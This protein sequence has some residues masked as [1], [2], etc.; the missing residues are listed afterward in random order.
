MSGKANTSAIPTALSQLTDDSTHRVVTDTEKTAWN[1]KQDALTFDNVPTQNSNNPVKSGGIKTYVDS[2][3]S[4]LNDDL[5]SLI[6]VENFSVNNSTSIASGN[7][8]GF[9]IPISKPGYTPVGIVGVG[10]L[11]TDDLS[12]MSFTIPISGSTASI[13]YM[14]NTGRA[15][16]PLRIDAKILFVKS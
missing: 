14:N 2:A 16:K 1:G 15:L 9:Q 8:Q 3:V 12:I 13:Y 10:G 6:V 7:Y 4:Q 5:D 11:G